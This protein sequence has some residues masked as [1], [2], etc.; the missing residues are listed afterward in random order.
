MTAGGQRKGLVV[1]R[2]TLSLLGGGG[3]GE[4]AESPSAKGGGRKRKVRVETA[5][6]E[7]RKQCYHHQGSASVSGG[8]KFP[9]RYP[10]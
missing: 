2:P 4:K 8:L 9:A 6:C 10:K 5:Q 3:G 1:I 7:W